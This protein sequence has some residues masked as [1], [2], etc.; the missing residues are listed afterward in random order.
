MQVWVAV[1][2]VVALAVV[3][4]VMMRVLAFPFLELTAVAM[5]VVV[6]DNIHNMEDISKEKLMMIKSKSL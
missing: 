3:V 5:E 4:L 2:E 1:V 6:V